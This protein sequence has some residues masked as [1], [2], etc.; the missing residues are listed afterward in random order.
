MREVVGALLEAGS[1]CMT[2]KGRWGEEGGGGWG[3]GANARV[4]G[5]CFP[6]PDFF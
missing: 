1:T 2:C 6:P 3:G 5:G 4:D